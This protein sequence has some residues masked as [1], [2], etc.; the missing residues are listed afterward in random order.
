MIRGKETILLCAGLLA[1]NGCASVRARLGLPEKGAPSLR[2]EMLATTKWLKANL[3]NPSVIVVHVARTREGYD[4]GHIPGA[5]FMSWND[6]AVTRN[7]IPNELPSVENLTALA[8]RLGITDD[9]SI[10]VYDEGA[11]L[12]AARAYVTF[13]HVGLGDRTALLDGQ[14]RKW[15]AEGGALSTDAPTVVPSDFAP[16]VRPGVI[17]SLQEM[18]RLVKDKMESR[19]RNVVIIDARPEEQYSGKQPGEGITRPGHIPAAVNVYWMNNV[20]GSDNPILQPI[21]KLRRL[22][23]RAG[24]KPGVEIITYCRTGVQAS[25][26]YFTVKYLGYSPRLYDGSFL[27]WNAAKDT[28]VKAGSEAK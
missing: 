10:V 23:S 12:E 13:D 5:R 19:D 26:S 22:Y 25:H 14:L 17:I 18:R 16:R 27:E 1:M 21:R 8:R 2:N 7:G 3:N 28:P 4:A 24:V 20:V 9:S 6:F 15:K 11:G